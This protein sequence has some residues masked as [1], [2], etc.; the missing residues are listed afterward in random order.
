MCSDDCPDCKPVGDILDKLA[1]T[2]H[3]A[4]DEVFLPVAAMVL[5]KGVDSDGKAGLRAGWTDSMDWIARRGML[6]I[7]LDQERTAPVWGDDSDD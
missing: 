2:V 1:V 7:A 3:M 5:I 4:D 6:E